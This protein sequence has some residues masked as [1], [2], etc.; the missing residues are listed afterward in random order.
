MG[1]FQAYSRTFRFRIRVNTEKGKYLTERDFY[2]RVMNNWSCDTAKMLRNIENLSPT[3][4]PESS[5]GH[6]IIK[7][8]SAPEVRKISLCPCPN[9]PI[10]ESAV[11]NG[12][13]VI[14]TNNSLP[15]I[16]NEIANIKFKR[17]VDLEVEIVF[18]GGES[19]ELEFNHEGR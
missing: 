16:D 18:R 1:E 12:P 17:G 8:T 4:I 6:F 2:I 15:G 3:P 9:D 5:D 10:I 11:D 13:F 19:M 14:P 7:P